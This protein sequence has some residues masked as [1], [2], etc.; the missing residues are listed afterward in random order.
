[1]VWWLGA[2]SLCESVEV[3][4]SDV[5]GFAFFIKRWLTYLQAAKDIKKIEKT[6][7]D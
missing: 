4:V 6:H 2:C 5:I 3:R 1:V 7:N